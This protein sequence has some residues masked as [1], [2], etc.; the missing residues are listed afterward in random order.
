[1]RRREFIAGLG[2]AA[3][4]PGVVRAQQPAVPVIGVLS[5]GDENSQAPRRNSTVLP[6]VQGLKEAGYVGNVAVESRFAEYQNDRLPVLAA[7]LVRRR[8]A[9]ILAGSTEAALAAKAATTTI[10][11]VFVIG[12][13][14]VAVGLVASLNRQ[15]RGVAGPGKAVADQR[16]QQP[17]V[18]GP[19]YHPQGPRR[20]TALH[21]NLPY[22]RANVDPHTLPAGCPGHRLCDRAHASESVPPGPA[23][24]VHLAEYVVQEHIGGTWRVRARQVAHDRVEPEYSFDPK[25]VS[26]AVGADRF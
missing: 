4:W 17:R 14:P 20:R 1:M 9:V 24:A 5:P 19:A 15:L 26:S 25:S 18:H 13:D 12:T 3:A 21:D 22:R 16:S 6:F 2:S 10:P 11:I 7:D 23:F 8:V